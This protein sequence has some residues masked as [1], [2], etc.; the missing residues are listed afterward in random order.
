MSL[1]SVQQ[2]VYIA[3]GDPETDNPTSL[4]F[5]G[6][7]GATVTIQHATQGRKT[8]QL[9]K[10]NSG[11]ATLTAHA[12]VFWADKHNYEVIAAATNHGRAAG[13]AKVAAAASTFCWIQKKGLG[14]VRFA[15][16]PTS[17]P[18]ATGKPVRP[19]AT[20]AEADSVALGTALDN[21]IARTAGTAASQL[22]LCDIDVDDR[23]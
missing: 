20:V 19:T 1:T 16:A 8:Y 23:A 18:D 10:V 12:C 22:A 17:A 4:Q 11:S 5:P 21:Q 14:L 7:L 2:A 9:V 6:Q 15:A 13:I 3:T